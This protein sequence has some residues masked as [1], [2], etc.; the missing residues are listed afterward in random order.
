MEHTDS[1]PVQAVHTVCVIIPVQCMHTHQNIFR[2]ALII[3]NTVILFTLEIKFKLTFDGN[4]SEEHCILR[5]LTQ[6]TFCILTDEN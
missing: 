4:V 3:H 2:K 1:P 5:A 6:A